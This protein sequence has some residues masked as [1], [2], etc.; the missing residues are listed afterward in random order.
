MNCKETFDDIN[1]FINKTYQIFYKDELKCKFLNDPGKSKRKIFQN[2]KSF[3]LIE[4]EGF[5]QSLDNIE[6]RMDTNYELRYLKISKFVDANWIFII[7]NNSP[8]LV[9]IILNKNQILFKGK[10]NILKNLQY[11]DVSNN[12][13]KDLSFIEQFKCDYLVYLDLSNNPLKRLN[14]DNLN[15]LKILKLNNIKLLHIQNKNEYKF[16]NKIQQIFFMNSNLYL[17]KSNSFLRSL[18]LV[19]I[20]YGE[21]FHYCCLIKKFHKQKVDCKPKTA[22]FISCSNLL[23]SN[24]VRITFWIF[25]ILGILLNF[26]S[27][28]LS[29]FFE[30]NSV[31]FYRFFISFSDFLTATYTLSLAIVD[32][33]FKDNFIYDFENWKNSIFCSIL[34]IILSYSLKY[35]LLSI[36]ALAV[37]RFVAVSFPFSIYKLKN[38]R[39]LVIALVNFISVFFAGL[40]TFLIK[41][42]L[43]FF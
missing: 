10:F 39:F 22:L 5:Y 16:F 36:L 32:I 38:K 29:L 30:Q 18:K 17:N 43:F 33:H 7:L 37:E 11:L 21:Y 20:F 23:N 35:S 41:V 4:M 6:N 31:K 26:L 40:P 42:F 12:L 15:F 3:K 9:T 24:S 28:L 2:I 13:I 27:I 8:N 14:I 1:H 25:G 19:K 34:N